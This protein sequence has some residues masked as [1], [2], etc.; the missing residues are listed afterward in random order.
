MI[1]RLVLIVAT[2]TTLGAAAHADESDAKVTVDLVNA[3]VPRVLSV[4]CRQAGLAYVVGGSVDRRMT[5]VVRDMPILDALDFIARA[6]G[7]EHAYYYRTIFMAPPAAHDRLTDRPADSPLLR[8]GW[9][10]PVRRPSRR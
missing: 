9:S 2:F 8:C 4:V 3:Q 10:L 6:S 5:M 1:L 7:C